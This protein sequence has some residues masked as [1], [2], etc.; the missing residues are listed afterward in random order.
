MYT[1]VPSASG[2]EEYESY[3]SVT[4]VFSVGTLGMMTGKDHFMIAWS[5][6]EMTDRVRDLVDLGVSDYD[7]RHKY[8]SEDSRDWVLKA[9]RAAGFE[10]TLVVPVSYRPFD[11]RWTYYHKDCHAS[12]QRR[13]NDPLLEAGNLALCVPRQLASLP[14]EHCFV[15]N[16]VTEMSLISNKRRKPIGFF[17][18][19]WGG[20]A[21]R[22][23]EALHNPTSG[24]I[25]VVGSMHS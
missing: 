21:T 5:R 17:R 10:P 7:I 15:T 4:D 22:Y 25:F 1:L 3:T 19:I 16:N 8:D 12:P 6:R 9:A 11:T 23:W 20:R 24:R 14:F 13:V 2:N 18:C